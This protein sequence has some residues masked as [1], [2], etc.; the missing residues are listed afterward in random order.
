MVKSDDKL[1]PYVPRLVEQVK[2]RKINRRDFLQTA[3]LLGLSASSAYGVLGLADPFAKPAAAQGAGGVYRLA[4]R[5]PALENPATYSWVYDSNVARQ[6]C[7]YLTRTGPDNVTRPALAEKWEASEDLKTWTFYLRKGVKWSNGDELVADQVIWN[8]KRWLDP[9]VGS[10]ILGL[11]SSYMTNDVDLGEKDSK[12]NPTKTKQI[13]SDKAIEKVDDHTI[14]INAKVPQLAVP[15]H[16]FHYPALIL[17][18]SENGKFG[19]GSI[20]T[21]PYSLVEYEVGKIVVAK[22]RE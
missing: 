3:T 14:R 12:G 20:G 10:S 15:E 1:H 2:E 19:K 6:V 11:M 5:V 17:H 7:E 18:P 21:G 4:M 13:W 9:K 16:L 8:M 22:R